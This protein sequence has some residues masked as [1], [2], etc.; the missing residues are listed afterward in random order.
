VQEF[1]GE[2]EVFWELDMRTRFRVVDNAF[3]GCVFVD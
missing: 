1:D 2:L 3:D